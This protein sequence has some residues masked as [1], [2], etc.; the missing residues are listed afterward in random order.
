M[1]EQKFDAERLI[2]R[3]IAKDP[4]CRWV[5]TLHALDEM[6]RDME[7]PCTQADI[8]HMLTN[9]QITWVEFKK[10]Q[11]WRAVGKDLD[12]R[13]ITAVVAVFANEPRIKIITV[14]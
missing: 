4:A 10:D 11:L 6:S 9:C 14:F 8:K 3:K 5:F 13:V 12:G 7:P 2:C 1:A